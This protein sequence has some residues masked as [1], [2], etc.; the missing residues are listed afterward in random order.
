MP[1][2]EDTLSA[3][4]ELMAQTI[5]AKLKNKEPILP[6]EMGH[7]IRFLKDNNIESMPGA[8]KK[9]NDI[10]D[11]LPPRFDDDGDDNVIRMAR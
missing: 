1:A 10:V 8:N 6:A 4:H 3:I 11:Q 2:N 7:I 5:L 9:I